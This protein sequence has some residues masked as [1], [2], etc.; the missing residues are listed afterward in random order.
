[1]ENTASQQRAELNKIIEPIERMIDGLAKARMKVFSTQERIGL[2]AAEVENQID[3]YYNQ[4]Q[5][6]YSNR[7]KI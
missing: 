1:M 2:Q 3:V 6:Q 7:E 4:L 5:Q